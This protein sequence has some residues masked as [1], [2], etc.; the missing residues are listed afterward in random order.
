MWDGLVDD[1]TTTA[2]RCPRELLWKTAKGFISPANTTTSSHF[3]LHH[4]HPCARE[5]C[6]EPESLLERSSSAGHSLHNALSDVTGRGHIEPVVT[7][8]RRCSA[9]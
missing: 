5:I 8:H 6:V 2:Q 1:L 4:T 3:C 7:S 9:L